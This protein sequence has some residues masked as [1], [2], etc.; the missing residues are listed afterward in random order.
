M[1]HI[2]AHETGEAIADYFTMFAIGGFTEALIMNN[3]MIVAQ[4]EK[5]KLIPL[6]FAVAYRLPALGLGYYFSIHLEMGAR[7][8]GLGTSLAGLA[9]F[10][11]SQIYLTRASYRKYAI[12]RCF[13]VSDFKKYLRPFINDGWQLALQ[14]LSEWVN[15]MALASVIGAWSNSSLQALEPALQ[16]NTLIALSLNGMTVAALMFVTRDC[17]AKQKHYEKFKIALSDDELEH[18]HR[19]SR[20]SKRDFYK[21]NLMGILLAG[22]LSAAI[23]FARQPITSL[24]L[25]STATYQQC[26]LAESLLGYNLIA[27]IIDSIRVVSGGMLRGW[28]DLLF[29]TLV[30]ILVMTIFGVLVAAGI[31]YYE[32]DEDP[33]PF[34]W[35]RIVAIAASSGI[36]CYRFWGHTKKDEQLYNEGKITL[37][38]L[39]AIKSWEG[40]EKLIAPPPL[41]NLS[42]VLAKTGFKIIDN[43]EEGNGLFTAV[44][45]SIAGEFTR[46]YIRNTVAEEI[47]DNIKKYS[48]EKK[49][50]FISKV[51]INHNFASQT[52]LNALSNAFNI[53]IVLITN[54]SPSIT[55][56]KSSAVGEQTVYLGYNTSGK[57]Y[58][59]TGQPTAEFVAFINKKMNRQ[60]DLLSS[61]V[62][63]NNADRGTFFDDHKQGNSSDKAKVRESYDDRKNLHTQRNAKEA[64]QPFTL[65]SSHADTGNEFN[66]SFSLNDSTTLLTCKLNS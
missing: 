20:L 16:A 5:N 2:V 57:Y 65:D 38:I 55:L 54:Q 60:K 15:V 58:A 22:S 21:T 59:L 51:N 56:V 34:F 42:E 25:E 19:L 47:A 63:T 29:P 64:T 44:A 13:N 32:Y 35:V 27:L 41:K 9:S 23:Y 17:T 14:R 48:L 36:N 1:P 53:N 30:S 37:A 12:Y 52:I 33:L 7:G 50:G 24:F 11:I 4:L 43:A 46:K 3:G 39:K 8:V 26:Q 6:L 28:G 31:S 10:C 18:F 61:C 45:R 62:Y 40:L 49:E 66:L